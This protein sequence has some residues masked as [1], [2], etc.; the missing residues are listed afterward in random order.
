MNAE[1]KFGAASLEMSL[2]AD[3]TIKHV[4][5]FWENDG[6]EGGR[7]ESVPA[8]LTV[9]KTGGFQSLICFNLQ[10]VPDTWN[11]APFANLYLNDFKSIIFPSLGNTN[12]P[13]VRF[14]GTNYDTVISSYLK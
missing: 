7:I 5:R 4:R 3:Y 14:E 10:Y 11:D 12:S 13:E 6:M 1:E 2:E 9:Q 8:S